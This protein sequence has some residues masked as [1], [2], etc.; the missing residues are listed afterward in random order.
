M[1]LPLHTTVEMSQVKGLRE[2]P[3]DID[4][5]LAA[6]ATTDGMDITFQVK[7]GKGAPIRGVYQ[8]EWWISESAIGAGLTADTYSGTVTTGTGTELQA[9]VAKKHFKGTTNADG[10]LVATAVASANPTD[11]YVAV[12]HPVTGQVLVSGVSGANWEGA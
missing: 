11:Q 8:L 2:A 6:S 12:K 3:F 1:S 5:T 7:D 4:I 10:K 9:I